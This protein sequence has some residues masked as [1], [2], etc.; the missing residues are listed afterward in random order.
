MPFD[1]LFFDK[2]KADVILNKIFPANVMCMIEDRDKYAMEV[3]N[4]GVPVYLVDKEYV[5]LEPGF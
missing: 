4:L 2:D 5:V 3:S 1:L